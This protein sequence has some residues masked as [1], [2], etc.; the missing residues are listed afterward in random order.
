MVLRDDLTRAV[1][2][3]ATCALAIAGVGLFIVGLGFSPTSAVLGSVLTAALCWVPAL[4]ALEHI[5]LVRRD[6]HDG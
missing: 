5:T 2:T 4:L 3:L 6:R 1:V